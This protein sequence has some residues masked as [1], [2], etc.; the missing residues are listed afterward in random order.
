[1]EVFLVKCNAIIVKK[2]SFENPIY[3]HYC[4][5]SSNG[6]NREKTTQY[7]SNIERITV[8]SIQLLLYFVLLFISPDPY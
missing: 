2:S 4:V 7:C 3:Y 6:V 1:M 8:D 5:L